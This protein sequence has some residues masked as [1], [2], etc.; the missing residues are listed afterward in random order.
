MSLVGVCVVA[1]GGQLSPLLELAAIA[2]PRLVALSVSV[3]A[4]P[5]AKQ[6]AT[7]WGPCAPSHGA[8]QRKRSVPLGAGS[9]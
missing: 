7:L 4:M 2:G 9:Y 8:G 6:G 5:I 3:P 1:I